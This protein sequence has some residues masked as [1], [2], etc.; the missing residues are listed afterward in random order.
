MFNK[1]TNFSFEVFGNVL[2]ELPNYETSDFYQEVFRTNN[3]FIENFLRVD[4]EIYIEVLSGIAILIVTDDEQFDNNKQF[5]IHR[6]V[7]LKPNVFFN[8]VA[9]TDDVTIRF[10][11]LQKSKVKTYNLDAN[12]Q[13]TYRPIKPEFQILEIFAYFYQV[14]NADYTFDGEQHNYFELTYV[15]SGEL[16]TTIDG[17]EFTLESG[18][19]ILYAPGEFHC[20]KTRHDMACSYV[21]ILFQMQMD[22]L[23]LLQKR[24]F[25]GRKTIY[26]SIKYFVKASEATEHHSDPLILTYLSEII[27]KLRCYEDL[28]VQLLSSSP[29]QQNFENELLNEI[30]IFIN[31]NIYEFLTIEDLC[32]KFSISRSSLQVLFKNNVGV[33]PKQYISDLKLSKSKVLIKQGKYTISEISSM[34]AFNSIHYFSR[35]FKQRYDIAPSDYAKTIY[36]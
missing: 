5:V 3:R 28:P 19:T 10:T 25:K 30:L 16:Q 4:Q 36:N 24:V 1:T 29:A 26:D 33:A 34:L 13:I 11:Y 7:R 17:Q 22:Q 35:K 23:E 27:A 20:Q 15:D 31:S 14:R 18:D 8:V 21:T 6:L 12:H 32:T 9:M 2:N